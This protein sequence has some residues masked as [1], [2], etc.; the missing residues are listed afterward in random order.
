MIFSIIWSLDTFISIATSFFIE[1]RVSKSGLK[2][3]PLLTAL[4]CGLE[5]KK[6]VVFEVVLQNKKSWKMLGEI[7]ILCYPIL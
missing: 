5:I 2:V 6:A 1:S 4:A 7:A 3:K